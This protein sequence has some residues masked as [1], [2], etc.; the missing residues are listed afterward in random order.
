MTL[1]LRICSS[2]FMTLSKLSVRSA[3]ECQKIT[4]EEFC[5]HYHVSLVHCTS[6]KNGSNMICC[7][8]C[9]VIVSFV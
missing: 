1:S 7:K 9:G 8:Y 4:H 5:Q 3:L 2:Y 6:L